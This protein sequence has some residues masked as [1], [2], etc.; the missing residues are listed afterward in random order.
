MVVNK[1]ADAMQCTCAD[2]TNGFHNSCCLFLLKDEKGEG[3]GT[4]GRCGGERSARLRCGDGSEQTSPTGMCS[5]IESQGHEKAEHH[6][7]QSSVRH[8]LQSQRTP[9][10]KALGRGTKRK[11]KDQDVRVTDQKQGEKRIC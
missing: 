10:E 1:Q 8:S 4:R 11:E 6:H 9:A 2:P 3:R 7:T 5:R